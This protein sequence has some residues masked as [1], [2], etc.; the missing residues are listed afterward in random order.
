VAGTTPKPWIIVVSLFKGRMHIDKI[1][2]HFNEVN[3]LH[4][5]GIKYDR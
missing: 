1:G 4:G 3:L 2:Y 5:S